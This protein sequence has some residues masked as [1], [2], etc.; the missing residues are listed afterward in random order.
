[1]KRVKTGWS[2]NGFYGLI[3]RKKRWA[4]QMGRPFHLP[5]KGVYWWN[6]RR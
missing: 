2:L 5:H 1:M 6:R 4:N 3:H